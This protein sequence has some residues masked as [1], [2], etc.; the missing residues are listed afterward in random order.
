MD[1]PSWS[2]MNHR[3]YESAGFFKVG[4]YDGGRGSRLFLFER[5][6]CRANRTDG[7]EISP[8]P[9][10]TNVLP[11][12]IKEVISFVDPHVRPTVD[13][14]I[15]AHWADLDAYPARRYAPPAQAGILFGTSSFVDYLL[16]IV[17]CHYRSD[18]A[19]LDATHATHTQRLLHH[20]IRL[21]LHFG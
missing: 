3:F 9:I 1:I 14:A 10:C 7:C 11:G 6:K 8:G 16:G 15:L 2:S 4:E 19:V 5:E 20:G 13:G 12:I 21:D 17:S 18:R